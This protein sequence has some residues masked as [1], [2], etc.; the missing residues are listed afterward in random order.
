MRAELYETACVEAE[1]RPPGTLGGTFDQ[2]VDLRERQQAFRAIER[3]GLDSCAAQQGIHIHA[4]MAQPVDEDRVIARR[5]CC[6]LRFGHGCILR[7]S[8]NDWTMAVTA[9]P[10]TA[11]LAIIRVS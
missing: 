6:R 10:S 4:E 5:K 3:G 1:V 9:K 11:R 2:R 7:M 8:E